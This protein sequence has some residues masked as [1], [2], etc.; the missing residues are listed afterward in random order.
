[1]R[2]PTSLCD[3]DRVVDLLTLGTT[4]CGITVTDMPP[5]FVQ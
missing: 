3:S 4:A 1:M 5:D 2:L